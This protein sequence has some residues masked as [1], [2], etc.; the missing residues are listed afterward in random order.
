M[1]LYF[2]PGA[3]SLAPHIFAHEA[4]L[5]LALERVDL[6]AK[7]TES[8]RDYLEINPMGAVPAL[9]LEG[10]EVLTENAVVLQY[11]A[12][13]A[14]RHGLTPAD[15]PVDPLAPWRLLETV[16][17]IAT[18]LHKGFGPMFKKPSDDVKTQTR[19]HLVGRLDLLAGKLGDKPLLAG[20]SFTIAD[21]YAYVMLRWAKKFE[22]SMP[23]TLEDYYERV[24]AREGVQRALKEEGLS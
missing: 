24:N 5:T 21:A 1:K 14:P 4:G 6:K 12:A 9:E 19:E 11:L 16:N 17:F 20:E 2:S 8:G 3:C 10:G 22:V 7:R 18:E 15:T 13:Q 23:L